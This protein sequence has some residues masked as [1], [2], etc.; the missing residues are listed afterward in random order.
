MM[1]VGSIAA[2]ASSLKTMGDIAKAMIDL[3]DAQAFQAKVIELNRE[4]MSAQGSALAA[5]ADHATMA[6]RVHGL[7]V[8]IAE[9]EA[10]DHEKERYQLTDH[11]GG[12]FTRALKPG[13][14]EGEPF[15]RICA[16]CYE[17]RRKSILQ[18]RGLFQ[19]REKVI[20][21]SCETTVMLGVFQPQTHAR[22]RNF[23]VFTGR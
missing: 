8:R 15:H 4:I 21:P 23:D 2:L 12:T 17:H 6:E 10:W 5:Q 18:S 1:D 19:G 7:E 14:E 9:L 3:R 22:G 13:K 20:C 11:G 16:H